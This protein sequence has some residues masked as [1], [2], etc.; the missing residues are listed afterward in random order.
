MPTGAASRFTRAQATQADCVLLQRADL[1]EH[2]QYIQMVTQLPCLPVGRPHPHRRV[3]IDG[4]AGGRG[5]EAGAVWRPAVSVGPVDQQCGQ[6]SPLHFSRD[7]PCGVRQR[8]PPPLA[9]LH[10]V[11]TLSVPSGACLPR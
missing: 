10:V 8:L 5:I 2:R 4:L 1:L 9:E 11:L 3:A 6:V 7:L